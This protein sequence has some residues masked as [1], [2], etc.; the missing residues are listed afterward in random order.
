MSEDL[1]DLVKRRLRNSHILQ[2]TCTLTYPHY[3][4]VFEPHACV[5][6]TLA[7]YSTLYQCR[8]N[9]DNCDNLACLLSG[10][11]QGY[12]KTTGQIT[13]EL[14]GMMQN[15][16]GKSPLKF[17]VDLDQEADPGIFVSVSLTL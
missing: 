10:S 8:D 9:T 2:A 16:S 6:V 4:Q 12:A 3:T 11:N 1:R 15:W 17:G 7:I 5:P 14:G 13:T